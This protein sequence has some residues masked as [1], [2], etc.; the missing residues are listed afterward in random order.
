VQTPGRTKVLRGAGIDG[1]GGWRGDRVV[2]NPSS[3][4]VSACR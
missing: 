4:I 2:A 1:Y 3:V